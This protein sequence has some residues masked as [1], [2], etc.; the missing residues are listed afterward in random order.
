MNKE[1]TDL[2]IPKNQVVAK[3]WDSP[4]EKV[5]T[6]FFHQLLLAVELHLRIQHKEHHDGSKRQLLQ[7]LPPKV[8]WDLALAQRWL[9]NVGIEQETISSEDSE[10]H[11]KLRSKKKQKNALK[12]FAR[13]LKWPN[14]EDLEYALDERDRNS[15]PV[16]ER[17]ADT[18]CWFTGVVL[19]GPTLPFVL[20][21][22]L[23]DCDEETGSELGYLTH[24]KPSCGFQYRANTYWSYKCIL[25]KVLGASRGVKQV[26]G[27]I[28]PCQFSP[29][30]GRSQ[31]LLIETTPLPESTKKLTAHDIE[32]M[33]IFSDVL[34]PDDIQDDYRVR[35]FD[36]P[37]LPEAEGEEI[38]RI[39]K[40]AFVEIRDPAVKQKRGAKPHQAAVVFAVQGFNLPIHLR[41][42]VDFICA[43]PCE[44]GPHPLFRG[45]R[46]R[47][48]RVEDG[49]RE[50]AGWNGS[51]ESRGS[52]MGS[53]SMALALRENRPFGLDQ[54]DKA[55]EYYQGDWF[56]EQPDLQDKT[57]HR[58]L[59][60]Q[61]E[62]EDEDDEMTTLV[63]DAS[64]V[65]DN[66]VFARAWC[67]HWGE[68]AVVANLKGCCVACAVRVA[69]AAKV[70]VVIVTEG[71]R[72]EEKDRGVWDLLSTVG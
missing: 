41:H 35:D 16:E 60:H 10:F 15:T 24:V 47:I 28:G 27:W 38:I 11:F 71:G 6:R 17:S 36:I 12:H 33:G 54:G 9:E 51:F 21:N 13:L 25:G 44:S 66:E 23:I 26:S 57:H 59:V 7:G 14:M 43:A 70:R 67:A 42:D 29:D 52:S 8:L 49:L 45:Y 30:L 39:Q 3:F 61:C 32:H 37:N 18:M 63:V 56:D 62:E 22:S 48:V 50:M 2:S 20:M 1:W 68:H 58:R 46:T 69:R 40:L 53:R 72:E 34:G 4:D 31:C 64:G 19:P 55:S 5:K 65:S